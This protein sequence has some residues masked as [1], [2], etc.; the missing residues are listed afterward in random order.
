MGQKVLSCS[1]HPSLFLET[2][3]PTFPLWSSRTP[4]KASGD[5]WF[6]SSQPFLPTRL[7]QFYPCSKRLY[8]SF[9]L[10]F[11]QIFASIAIVLLSSFPFLHVRE[12]KKR[13]LLR[14]LYM[15][16]QIICACTVVCCTMQQDMKIHLE[17]FAGHWIL[18]R[19]N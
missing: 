7:V 11:P 10:F 17:L 18:L 5:P 13:A 19:S 1:H 12:K 15:R 14:K 16:R 6:H 4:N 3:C 8:S 9:L 2:R